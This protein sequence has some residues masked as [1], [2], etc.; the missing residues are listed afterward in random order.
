MK[1]KTPGWERFSHKPRSICQR[2]L[3]V[4]SRNSHVTNQI[5]WDVSG[6]AAYSEVWCSLVANVKSEFY[7]QI[8][9]K[10]VKC[11]LCIQVTD[12]TD[13][14]LLFQVTLILEI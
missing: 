4:T 3:K 9:S 11:D 7:K 8:K 10:C 12:F 2:V 14:I 6:S 1:M 5:W 13:H